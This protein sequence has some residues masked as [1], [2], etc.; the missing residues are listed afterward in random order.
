MSGGGRAQGG[1]EVRFGR[2]GSPPFVLRTGPLAGGLSGALAS[3]RGGSKP[4]SPQH[5]GVCGKDS[6]SLGSA[7]GPAEAHSLASEGAARAGRGIHRWRS[8]TQTDT[9]ATWFV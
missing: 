7:H 1:L 8:A 9:R 5:P 2:G 4:A 3:L 6:G